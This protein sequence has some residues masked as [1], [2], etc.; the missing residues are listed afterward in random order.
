MLVS[1]SFFLQLFISLFRSDYAL[2]IENILLK[3]ENEI[4]KRKLNLKR[5]HV[6]R[7]DKLF[8]VILHLI[9]D[10]RSNISIVTPGTLLHWQ[11]ILIKNFWTFFKPRTH[12]GRPPVPAEVKK[13]ILDMKNE[14]LN[15]GTRRIR[16][17]LLK[18]N[19][20]LHR[21]TIQN[22]INHFHRKGKIRKSLTWKQ[23]LKSHVDSLFAMDYFTVDTIFN[24]RYFVFFMISHKTREIVQFSITQNP[25]REFVKQQLIE[26]EQSCKNTVY[27]IHDRDP[28]FMSID[29][30]SY[31]IRDVATS[32]KAPNMNSIAERFVRTVRNEALDNFIILNQGQL[33]KVLSEY[34]VFYNSMRP[35]QGIKAI[36]G[37]EP[38][39]VQ[40]S[41]FAT[42]DIKKKSVLCDLHHHYFR[43][44]A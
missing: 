23:F 11:R 30:L 10:I 40:E 32:V 13:L 34:V 28:G 37:K 29:Y 21:K 43:D 15:W 36:P 7:Y 8:L 19:I 6:S 9:G 16:D 12:P 2:Y 25:T 26:F 31:G 20:D 35:H 44:V 18:L 22:I 1:I 24:K 4:L 33:A 5:M 3:K 27:L 39:D 38:P 14:N 17:E 42:G 41:D